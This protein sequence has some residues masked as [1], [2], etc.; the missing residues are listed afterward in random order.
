M[1]EAQ[2]IRNRLEHLVQEVPGAEP[3]IEQLRD[4]M[5]AEEYTAVAVAL[6]R[7]IGKSN[8]PR[9]P[10]LGPRGPGGPGGDARGPGHRPE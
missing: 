7:L 10:G 6:A 2:R 8:P 3:L 9:A 5:P 4:G 1:I